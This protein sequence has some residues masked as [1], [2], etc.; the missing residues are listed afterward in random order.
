[1]STA[2]QRRPSRPGLTLLEVMLSL[3]LCA[4]MMTTSFVVLRSSHA[5]WLA[6]EADLNQSGQAAALLRHLVQHVRQASTVTSVTAAGDSSGSLTVLRSDGST[7]TWDHSGTSVTLS[8]DG[9]AAQPLADDIQG[10][11]F[12]GLAADTTTAAADP[13]DV[14][15]LRAEVTVNQPA[16][17]ART[18]SSNIWLRSW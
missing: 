12:E 15:L 17:G 11:E 4:V 7:L 3:S 14:H 6:H 18:V 1:M 2:R 13:S 10:L 16:G 5:A 9:G 8:L